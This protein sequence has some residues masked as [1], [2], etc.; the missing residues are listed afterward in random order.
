MS[1][2]TVETRRNGTTVNGITWYTRREVAML[3]G[4]TVDTVKRWNRLGKMPYVVRRMMQMDRKMR[5]MAA[6]P[7]PC[8]NAFFEKHWRPLAMRGRSITMDDLL[9]RD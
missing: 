4:V 3:L 7:S 9:G 5:R 8:I 2:K 1:I 6:I